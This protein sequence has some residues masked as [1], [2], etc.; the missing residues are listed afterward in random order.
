[1]HL[2]SLNITELFLH[3]WRG[4][5]E[6]DKNDDRSTWDWAVLQ[7]DVWKAHGESVANATPY[8]PG[9]FDRPPRNPCEKISSGYK[10]WEFLLYFYALGPALFRGVLPDIYWRHYCKLVAAIRMLHQRSIT[11]AQVVL[12]HTY[13]TEFIREF[14]E[15]Y[16]QRRLARL[17]F[18]R[19]S[20]HLLWHLAQEVVRVGP[21]AYYT[22]W[23]MERTIGNLGEEIKQPLKPYANLSER[24]V[25]RYALL[26][27]RDRSPQLI[28]GPAAVAIRTYLQEHDSDVD[29]WRPMLTRWARLALA[30]GQNARSAWKECQKPLE[31]LRTSRNVKLTLNGRTQ[32]AEVQYFFLAPIAAEHRPLALVSLYS[33]PDADLLQRSHNTV[34]SCEY[35]GQDSLIVINAR[36]IHSVVAIVPEAVTALAHSGNPNARSR[37]FVAE[38]LGLEVADLSGVVELI[39]EE[40]HEDNEDNGPI[41]LDIT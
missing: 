28:T 36:D 4:S 14:E 40:D 1:M 38:K 8:L 29:H 34:Y 12:A 27:A 26:R 3:L 21:P 35:Q 37:F 16:Y 7:G 5:I 30:T 19:Q 2:A 39:A 22:Q 17:H 13:L 31:K 33:P 20:I 9:S 24:A 41:Q 10:A 23:T 18:C 32:F 11:R 25:R 15:L 6:C